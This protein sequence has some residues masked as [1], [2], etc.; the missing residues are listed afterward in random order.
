M[1]GT[2]F[3]YPRIKIDSPRMDST[4]D[5]KINKLAERYIGVER[6]FEGG[7]IPLY[8]EENN[9]GVF[10]EILG[11]EING[12]N[13]YSFHFGRQLVL[14]EDI[15]MLKGNPNLR[16]I[17][18]YQTGHTSFDATLKAIEL[19]NFIEC[20]YVFPNESGKNLPGEGFEFIPHFMNKKSLVSLYLNKLTKNK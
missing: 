4:L 20:D 5:E 13:I 16:I 12:H 17:A 2:K 10:R 14:G 8:P 9:G 7:P 1:T 11:I 18:P 15:E 3:F 19:G 6:T